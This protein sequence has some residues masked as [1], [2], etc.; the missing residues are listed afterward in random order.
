MH[1]QIYLVLCIVAIAC[2]RLFPMPSDTCAA[3]VAATTVALIGVPHGGLDHWEGKRLLQPHLSSAWWL[4]FFPAYLAIGLSVAIGWIAMPL[5]TVLLFFLASAWHFGREDQQTSLSTNW[6]MIPGM[7]HVEAIALGGLIIWVPALLRP[8][9]FQTLIGFIISPNHGSPAADISSAARVMAL[10]FLPLAILFTVD[11]LV[12]A[13]TNSSRW[14]PIATAT[15]ALG[16]PILLSFPLYF[17]GWHSWQGL[18]RLR[19]QENLS[20]VQFLKCVAPLSISAIVGVAVIGWMGKSWLA[21]MPTS[22]P[23]QDVVSTLFIGLSSIAV[24]HL[25]LHEFRF[26]TTAYRPNREVVV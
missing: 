6:H 22:F 16:L 14:V 26:F 13:P 15:A 12:V 2:T 25:L 4:A 1:A 11:R 5:P 8:I 24:P 18:Q 9:E 17:C 3:I 21:Q 7:R 19:R 20:S 10:L 23:A